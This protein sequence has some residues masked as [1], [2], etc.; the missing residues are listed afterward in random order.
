MMKRL[1]VAGVQTIQI[2][3]QCKCLQPF[4]DYCLLQY[5][6]VLDDQPFYR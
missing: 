6:I 2:G 1:W 4:I 3:I 5:C